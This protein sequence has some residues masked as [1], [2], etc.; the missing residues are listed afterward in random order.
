MTLAPSA[1]PSAALIF[2][3]GLGTRMRPLTDDRPK[4]LVEV[5]GRTLLDRALDRV[6]EAGI[7]RAV[8]NVHAFPDQMR[9]AL[10]RRKDLDILV[11]DE[12]DLL[13]E[14]GGGM[15]KALPLLGPGPVLAL[16]ADAVWTGAAPVPAL[17]EA[18]EGARM[19]LL[20]L[21]VE[22]ARAVGYARAGDFLLDEASRLS[23]PPAGEA[24]PWVYTGA[25]ILDPALLVDQPE[26][27][28]SLS[29]VFFAEASAGR[30]SGLRH[31]GGWAD[32][33]T[34]AGIPAAE[35]LLRE[36]GEA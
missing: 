4:A 30:A 9:A 11:S 26:G 36:A 2:A 24:A 27:P 29:R 5:G 33:G 23:R 13:L 31:A 35:A 15:R 28:F 34:P 16:N 3:A 25:Q 14:T 22:K 12:S 32:V 18:W 21:V 20:L 19:G 6:K 8:V 17:L 1:A 10:A 7:P